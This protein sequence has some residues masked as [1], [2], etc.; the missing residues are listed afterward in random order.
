VTTAITAISAS[1]GLALRTA[2]KHSGSREATKKLT[3]EDLQ[4]ARRTAGAAAGFVT[5]NWTVAVPSSVS[6]AGTGETAQVTVFAAGWQNR[7]MLL[8]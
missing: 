2:R 7:V 5:V 6:D 3:T 8:V 4:A 1:N